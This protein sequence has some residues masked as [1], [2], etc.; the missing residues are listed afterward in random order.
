MLNALPRGTESFARLL[1]TKDGKNGWYVK[2]ISSATKKQ[3][4]NRW[5]WRH[6]AFML[7]RKKGK[8]QTEFFCPICERNRLAA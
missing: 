7:S 2:K 5:C 8:G 4:E 3:L 1:E 6:G